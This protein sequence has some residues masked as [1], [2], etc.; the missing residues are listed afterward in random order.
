MPDQL[1]SDATRGFSG[2]VSNLWQAHGKAL[3]LPV[4]TG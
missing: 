3:L 2:A 1:A 4:L